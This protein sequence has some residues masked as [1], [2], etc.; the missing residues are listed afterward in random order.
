MRWGSE[1]GG[2]GGGEREKGGGGGGGEK[3]GIGSPWINNNR[4][5]SPLGDD[6]S[7]G[8]QRSLGQTNVF[9]VS[10]SRRTT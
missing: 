6:R 9:I 4:N 10:L 2:G 8:K 5:P 1:E 3:E 7:G